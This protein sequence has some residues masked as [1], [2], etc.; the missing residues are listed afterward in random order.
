MQSL[1][2]LELT[3]YLFIM[4]SCALHPPW[5][6]SDEKLPQTANAS[7]AVVHRFSTG[8]DVTETWFVFC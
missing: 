5:L 6:D 1:Q 2:K 4:V 8:L 7:V 3:H